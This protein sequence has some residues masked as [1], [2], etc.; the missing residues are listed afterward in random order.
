MRSCISTPTRRPLRT[1]SSRPASRSWSGGSIGSAWR[2]GRPH[3]VPAPGR[4]FRKRL[5]AGAQRL[6]G[7]VPLRARGSS[8][9]ATLSSSLSAPRWV[10]GEDVGRSPPRARRLGRRSARP[11][12]LGWRLASAGRWSRA[13]GSSRRGHP[14]NVVFCV[15]DPERRFGPESQASWATPGKIVLLKRRKMRTTADDG[16]TKEIPGNRPLFGAAGTSMVRKGSRLESGRCSQETPCQRPRDEHDW[17][18]ESALRCIVARL[19]VRSAS[20]DE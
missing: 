16:V 11:S 5:P 2:S 20:M 15:G 19:E 4:S 17:A 12:R 10:G 7:R 8:G 9:T 3:R 1:R 13:T 18:R 14:S 6:C